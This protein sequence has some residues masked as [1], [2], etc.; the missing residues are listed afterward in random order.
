MG[1]FTEISTVTKTLLFSFHQ[2]G[3]LQQKADE[4]EMTQRDIVTEYEEHVMH[5]KEEVKIFYSNIA[6]LAQ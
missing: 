2:V 1:S 6:T 3:K 4:M 5:L